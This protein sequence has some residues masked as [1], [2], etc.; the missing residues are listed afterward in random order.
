MKV[1]IMLREIVVD[2]SVGLDKNRRVH[3]VLFQSNYSA[4]INRNPFPDHMITTEE[5]LSLR[6][7]LRMTWLYKPLH[8]NS[9][10]LF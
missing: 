10:F 4:L 1:R 9:R 7:L 8:H 3:S 2:S 5:I 6:L